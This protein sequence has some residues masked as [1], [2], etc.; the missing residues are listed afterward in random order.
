MPTRQTRERSGCGIQWFENIGASHFI[1]VLVLGSK[2][3]LNSNPKEPHLVYL[4]IFLSIPFIHP[5]WLNAI[6]TDCGIFL[7]S[8][9]RRGQNVC[10]PTS[11]GNNT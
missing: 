7:V 5:A 6:D 8:I 1:S 2:R 11:A 10:V 3:K 4:L 9:T